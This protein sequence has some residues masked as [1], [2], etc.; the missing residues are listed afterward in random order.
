MERRDHGRGAGARRIALPALLGALAL[1]MLYAACFLPT[2]LWGWTAVAGLGPLAAVASLGVKSGLLCWGGVSILAVLLLP[3]KFCALLFTLMFGIY[4]VV[5]SL[6]ERLK[7]PVVRYGAK[8]LFFN[9]SFTVLLLTMG[10]LMTA[11]LPS[12][13]AQR[14]WVMY[15]AGN[16]I[17]LIY[18]FGLTRLIGFYLARVDRAVRRGGRFG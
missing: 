16:V 2:G 11:T 9:A 13:I 3:D 1:L 12:A 5:K 17:F 4:P 15:A 14:M 7:Q 6:A 18:D 10:A 8:L